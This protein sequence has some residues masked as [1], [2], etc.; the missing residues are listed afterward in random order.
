MKR[1]RRC[2]IPSLTS[3]SLRKWRLAADTTLLKGVLDQLIAHT[4]G[5][6]LIEKEFKMY[7]GH[8]VL[9]FCM[10]EG[11]EEAKGRLIIV[12]ATLY[13]LMITYPPSQVHQLEDNPF[14]ESFEVS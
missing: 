1:I 11:E 6:E 13:R 7:Q 9:D 4:E 12:G 10:K 3:T 2:V 14:L 5:A 8:R